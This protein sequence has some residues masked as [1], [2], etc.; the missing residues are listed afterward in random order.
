MIVGKTYARYQ[1]PIFSGTL[2]YL[3]F[4]PYWNIPWSIVRRELRQ[5]FDEPGYLESKDIEIVSA[6]GLNAEPLPIN[7]ENLAKVGRGEYKVR[8][9]PGSNNALGLVKFIFPNQH[10]VFL[11]STPAQALFGKSER[12]FSHGCVRVGDPVGLAEW[13]LETKSGWERGAIESSMGSGPP[14]RVRLQEG[15]PVYIVYATAFIDQQ[16]HRISFRPDIYGL[17]A[18]LAESLGESM[19]VL[20]RFDREYQ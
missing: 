6:F 9:R 14:T 18:S 11:H 13:V 17:D 16:S 20:D 12:A 3:D 2:A 5:H 10:S 15:I 4:R 1:T 8:Q 7:E 19:S